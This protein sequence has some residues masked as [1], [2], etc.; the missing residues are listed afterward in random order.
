MGWDEERANRQRLA[1]EKGAIIKDWGG[2]I[3]VALVHPSLYS[4]GMSSLG[5]QTIYG[6]LNK[7]PRVVCERVFYPE[8]AHQQV[9]GT[10]SSRPLMDFSILAFSL[11]YE[12][13]YVN[14]L[15]ILRRSGIP[16]LSKDRDEKYPLIIAGGPCVIS[17]FE[18]LA[19]F[20]DAF[21]LGEAEALLPSFLE[22][23]QTYIHAPGNELLLNISSVPGFH[24]PNITTGKVMRQWVKDI[25][26]FDTTS[27][28]LSPDTELANMFLIEAERGC[29][30]GCRFCLAGQAFKPMRYRSAERIVRSAYRG[31]ELTRKIGLVGAA[32]LDHPQIEKVVTEIVE[33]GGQVSCS[34]L[35]GD[36]L[37]ERLVKALV[38]GG[39]RSLTIAPETGSDRLRALIGKDLSN[40]DILKAAEL[41]AAHGI[42]QLKLYFMIGLPGEEEQDIEEIISLV[43]KVKEIVRGRAQDCHMVLNIGPFIPKKGTPFF[44]HPMARPELLNSRVGK[45]KAALRPQDVEIK[46]ESIHWCQIQAVLSRGDGTISAALSRVKKNTI[47]DWHTALEESRVDVDYWAHQPF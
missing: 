45:I 44:R 1:R 15:D 30:R 34:S 29:E 19:P 10:E 3:S 23:F 24:V 9:V 35:R 4:A 42:R 26:T 20:F 12:L 6:F 22:C 5:F 2:K 8:S 32:I 25:D 37:T 31:L 41:A 47:K 16:L 36:A 21:G 17:N 40:E 11:S 43:V 27:V 13:D 14:A 28:V 46:P 39:E 38:K 18:P 33:K 7:F